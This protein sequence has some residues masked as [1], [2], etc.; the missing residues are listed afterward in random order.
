MTSK[1]KK[2]IAFNF[3]II[4]L[5][6]LIGLSIYGYKDFKEKRKKENKSRTL[7]NQDQEEEEE[8]EEES[9]EEDHLIYWQ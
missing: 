7:E 4:I 1:T 3:I 5:G 9:D 6:I 8:E 2:V